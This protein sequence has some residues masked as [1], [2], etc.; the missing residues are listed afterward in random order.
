MRVID[1]GEDQ[2]FVY[3]TSN[4]NEGEFVANYIDRR[5]ALPPATVF[6][7]LLQ[8]L[9]DLKLLG[10]RPRL[11]TQMRLDRVMVSTLQDTFL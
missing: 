11:V 6:S 3:Y 2:G 10:D 5:G 1:V 8:M 9:D 7:I 4:L